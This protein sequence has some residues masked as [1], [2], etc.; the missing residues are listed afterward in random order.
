MV[1]I[2]VLK[3]QSNKYYVGKTVDPHF[4]LETHFNASGSAWTKKYHPTQI[5]HII[6]DQ[7]DHDEQRV[8]QEYM[9]KYGIDNVR[10]GPWCTLIIKEETKRMIQQMFDSSAD[11]CYQCGSSDH[12]AKDCTTKKP[13]KKESDR[14]DRCGRPGHTNDKCYAQT[15]V[16]GSK[17]DE[18]YEVWGCEYCG[19]EFDTE[20]GCIFHENTHCKKKPKP[21]QKSPACKRCG[22][23]GHSKNGC[24]AQKHVK[25]Y[26]L[27]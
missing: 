12:F 17:L 15:A 27:Y 20:K 22:R 10:G 2:Y 21:K 25:G 5:H 6:P 24:Y 26:E 23:P 1:Y 7:S 13:M 9:V 3:L 19:K 16:D 11:K 18:S 4:R 14:C 8:T